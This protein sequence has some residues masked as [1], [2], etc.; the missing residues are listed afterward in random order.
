MKAMSEQVDD[1]TPIMFWICA[2]GLYHGFRANEV[3]SL[4]TSDIIQEFDT[5]CIDLKLPKE[6]LEGVRRGKSKTVP[7][8]LPLHPTLIELGFLEFVARQPTGRI[9]HQLPKSK[10]GYYSRKI[11]DWGT[12]SIEALG[13]KGQKLSFHSFR[14][15]FLDALDEAGLP[16]K[17]KAHLGGWRLKGV[18]NKTYGSREMKE[19]I[20]PAIRK[21]QYKDLAMTLKDLNI[22]E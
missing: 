9:F 2:L 17:W 14:H 18:M 1:E 19:S 22:Q 4:Q 3:A 12:A 6:L 8:K 11:S 16:E 20:I 15:T 5:T 10:D 13:W 21:V 7:R